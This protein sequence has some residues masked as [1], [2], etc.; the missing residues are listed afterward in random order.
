M[1]RK[2][3][4]ADQDATAGMQVTDASVQATVATVDGAN[5]ILID[6]SG[7]YLRGKLSLM[8]NPE[9]IRVGGL[10]SQSSGW[11]Q[12][13]PSTM[14]FPNPNLIISSPLKGINDMAQAV[15]W[16]MGLLL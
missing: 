11:L 8:M 15:S 4:K 16:M 2:T 6:E 12:M 13:F 1:G 10:W 5:G 9:Q 3:W 7:L 14:A